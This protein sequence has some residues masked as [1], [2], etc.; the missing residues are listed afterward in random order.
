MNEMNFTNEE[1]MEFLKENDVKPSNIRLK[2]FKYLLDYRI[3]PSVDDIYNS[4]ID[5]IPTLSR[6]SIYNTMNLFREKGI[7]SELFLNEKEL[8]YDVNTE[9]HGHFKCEV[10][11][12]IYDFPIVEKF[13]SKLEGFKVKKK[14]IN[15]YG[16][17]AKCNK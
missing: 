4:L 6:T 3:H 14:S 5:E 9:L 1:I 17:C 7:V 8:R 11:G 10:C 2:V 12:N 15:Y 16:I 13:I